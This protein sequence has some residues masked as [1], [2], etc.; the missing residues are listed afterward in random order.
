MRIPSQRVAMT[1][2]FS[3]G[4]RPKSSLP[5]N[6]PIAEVAP[7]QQ[8]CRPQLAESTIRENTWL[9]SQLDSGIQTISFE[10]KELP[11]ALY[12]SSD[13]ESWMDSVSP[14]ARSACS[15]RIRRASTLVLPRLQA[16]RC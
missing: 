4:P 1:P 10:T 5:C 3:S 15:S 2:Q 6:S 11:T 9:G 14:I 16:Q 13:D 8:F 7:D 12:H